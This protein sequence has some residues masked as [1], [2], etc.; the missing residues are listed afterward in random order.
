MEYSSLPRSLESKVALPFNASGTIHA[1]AIW[2]DYQLDET[3]RWSSF[4][5]STK[6]GEGA[7][8]APGSLHEKQMLR[9][10]P[11]PEQ[12]AQTQSNA[13]MTYPRLEIQGRFDV[14]GGCMEFDVDFVSA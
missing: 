3:G 4:G 12:V 2:T 6:G 10:L 9:F 14:E 11:Q 7:S 8:L 1:V 5:G 13:G